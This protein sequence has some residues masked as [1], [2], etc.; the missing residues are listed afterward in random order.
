[1]KIYLLLTFLLIIPLT[2][3]SK[4][5]V[6]GTLTEAKSGEIC[7]GISVV[8]YTDSNTVNLKPVRGAYS[9]KFGFFSIPNV[10]PGTYWVS[11]HGLG[12]QDLISPIFLNGDND[13]VL[14]LQL[15]QRD[16]QTQEL[17][18]EADRETNPAKTISTT[19]ISPIFVA[20]MPSFLGENDIFRVLQLLP[21]VTQ[22][23]ELSSGLYIRGGTP[24][25]NLTYLDGV[26]VYNPYHF[27]GLFSAF[28]TDAIKD[29]SLIK[30][31]YPAEYGGGIGGIIDLTMKE[32][33]SEKFKGSASVSLIFS[34]LTVEG[35]ITNDWTF[36]ISGR[37]S[38]IDILLF[39]LFESLNSSEPS[40]ITPKFY[41][42]DLNV[43][44]NYKISPIDRI[45]LSGYFGRDAVGFNIDENRSTG[46]FLWDW[47]NSTVNARWMHI[48]SPKLFT[49]FCAIYTNYL[50]EIEITEKYDTN[51]I[52]FNT[53]SKIEDFVLKGELQAFPSEKHILK[54]GS[55]FTYHNFVA[56]ANTQSNLNIDLNSDLFPKTR[57]N[58]I[59]LNFYAQDEWKPI[60]A[61]STN[62]GIHGFYFY[63]TN[64]FSL[65]PRLSFAY[66]LYEHTILKSS[67]AKSSQSLHLIERNGV[68]LPTDLWFP[69]T[70][71]I[72]PSN[73]WQAVLG[74]EQSFLNGEYSITAESYYRT[75]ENLYEFRDTAQ[76]NFG[77]PLESQ[78]TRGTGKAYGLEIMAQKKVGKLSG[79]ISYTLS[80]TMAQT[81]ELNQ[82]RWYYLRNDSRNDIRIA[83]T[84]EINSMF[85][86]S[87]SWI[88]NTG[89]AY[90]VPTSA[91]F[92]DPIGYPHRGSGY[93]GST[94]YD[95]SERNGYRLPPFHKLD[96]NI[97]YKNHDKYYPYEVFLNIYNAYNRHNPYMWYVANDGNGSY[98]KQIYLLPLIPSVGFS[99]KF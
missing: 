50:S 5:T 82:G 12:Y 20:K 37:R 84:Y 77:F 54:F 40:S 59:D 69:S 26:R 18:V 36:M 4:G 87:C 76:F 79:W 57:M 39:P 83:L 51:S 43:K 96:L 64:Y 27:G 29:I 70:N 93:G 13:T 32:G 52:A 88:Y 22:V 72:L 67:L 1:M 90:T 19:K 92:Y 30:G 48:I 80:R 85:E 23:S 89:Q 25:Q 17:T 42:Y 66:N 56:N 21:G 28:N 3:L 6:A 33:S 47:G 11:A 62:L 8:L 31:A 16:I 15:K 97:A 78:L 71:L 65:E 63:Q 55:E 68:S 73:S 99:M 53:L 91:Y 35:P 44:T 49:N 95:Y 60:P 34:R 58:A 41:F 2:L 94:S 9:N 45:F 10:S 14:N 98:I 75:M 86:A 24:D 61:I 38:Y 81:P 46:G 74:L 7:I